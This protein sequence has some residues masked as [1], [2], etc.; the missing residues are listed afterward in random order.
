MRMDERLYVRQHNEPAVKRGGSCVVVAV[1]YICGMQ[2]MDAFAKRE[3][4]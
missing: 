3:V 4:L 1:M 2:S